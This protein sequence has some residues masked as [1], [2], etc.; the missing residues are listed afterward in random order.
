MVGSPGADPVL[1]PP[2]GAELASGEAALDA[3]ASEPPELPP[4]P[5]TLPPAAIVEQICWISPR[6]ATTTNSC[7]Y[8]VIVKKR[9]VLP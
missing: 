9:I 3:A 5:P 7:Q 1:D 2:E 4:E 8:N 6:T